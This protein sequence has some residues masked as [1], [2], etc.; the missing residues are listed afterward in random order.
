MRRM[1]ERS[2]GPELALRKILFS[3]GLRY[4]IQYPVPGVPR[5]TIDI[6]FPGYKIAVFIDGCF[7]HG[8]TEHRTIPKHNNA[9]WQTKIDLNRS[10]DVDTDERLRAASWRVMRF[11]EH[12][13]IEQMA[14]EIQEAVTRFKR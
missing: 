13:D 14:A 2:T 11:W 1:P 7:W 6:A 12:N 8:C 3:L 9:W 4:R 10:R 5:R